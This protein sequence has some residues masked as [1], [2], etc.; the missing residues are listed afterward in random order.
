MQ[1]TD[2][3]DVLRW[4][5]SWL[6]SWTRSTSTSLSWRNPS[7]SRVGLILRKSWWNSSLN[8]GG[9]QTNCLIY[10]SNSLIFITGFLIW[11]FVFSVAQDQHC[12]SCGQKICL[13][14]GSVISTNYTSL[15][16][17]FK[18]FLTVMFIFI[19]FQEDDIE[20]IH[21]VAFAEE[22]DPGKTPRDKFAIK[23]FVFLMFLFWYS[24]S[25]IIESLILN[26]CLL[27]NHG[28]RLLNSV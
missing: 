14:L 15:V 11:S 1:C 24:C 13:R 27:Q 18:L 10:F 2:R 28:Q 9:K 16:S 20:G 3:S 5:K 26:T 19:H 4:P 21:I 22:E 17:F 25:K 7:P 6:W 23:H 12:E 8:T